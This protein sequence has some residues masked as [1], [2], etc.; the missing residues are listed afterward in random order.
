MYNVCIYTLFCDLN[1]Y[2][3][4]SVGSFRCVAVC[5]TQRDIGTGVLYGVAGILNLYLWNCIY[6]HT[7]TEGGRGRERERERE[8]GRERDKMEREGKG[9]KERGREERRMEKGR[10][11]ERERER[12][13][14]RGL[15]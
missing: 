12:G 1:I 8:G 11:E 13:R 4:L 9:K 6:I 14:K 5:Q 7:Q 2:V 10:E 3:K 15:A